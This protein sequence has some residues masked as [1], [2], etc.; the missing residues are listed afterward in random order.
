MPSVRKRSLS[1][2]VSLKLF[3]LKE[4]VGY[5][6][7][8]DVTFYPEQSDFYV[9]HSILMIRQFDASQLIELIV[10][11]VDINQMAWTKTKKRSGLIMSQWQPVPVMEFFKNL[12][13]KL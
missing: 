6:F 13:N 4:L 11:G 10:M 3:N 12:V 5:P 8:E 1:N 2:G 7:F 9:D